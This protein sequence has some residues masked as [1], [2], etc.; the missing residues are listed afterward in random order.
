M[1][2]VRWLVLLSA[3]A[4][5]VVVPAGRAQSRPYIGY[6]YPAGGK[7]GT[8]FEV[9]L[10]GQNLNDVNGVLVTGNGVSARVVEYCFPLGNRESGW[11]SR[12][13]ADLKKSL[14]KASSKKKKTK[15]ESTSSTPTAV[16]PATTNLIAR[17]E[18]LLRE[19]MR[20]PACAAFRSVVF[21][22]VTI[23]PDA[24]PGERELRLMT[25]RGG[26]SNPMAFHVGL[27]TENSR[28]AMLTAPRQRLGK[29]SQAL[30]N[31][32]S[33]EAEERINIPCTVNGQ[34][35][36]REVNSYRFAARKGQQLVI[37]TLARQLIP[38]I[39]DG[40]PG[41][42]Q[43]VI[44]LYDAN[45]REVAYDDDY[46]FKPDPVILYEVP[47]D[48]E[49]VLA[50]FDAIYR[51][52]NDFIY[53]ITIGELPFISNIYPL[54]GRANDSLTLSIRGFNLNVDKYALNLTGVKPGPYPFTLGSRER[55]TNRVAFMVDTLTETVEKEAN[56]TP[57]QAQF[58][59]LPIIIN[60]RIDKPGDSDVFQFRGRANDT[61]VVEVHARRLDS[62]LDS[63]VRI[64]DM[65]GVLVA[66]NDDCEDL[67]SGLNTHHADSYIMA[68]L[69]SDGIYC[70]H[71][72]DTARHGGDEYGY[73]LRI[74]APRPDF[75]LRVVP[76]SVSLRTKGDASL[77]V[78]AIRKDGFSGD[79]K[80]HLHNPPAGFTSTPV[81]LSRTQAVARLRLRGPSTPTK[82]PVT[83]TVA[84]TTEIGGKGAVHVAVPAE[85]RMQAF[86]WRHLVPAQDL[87]VHVYDP[88]YTPP[89]L[90]VPP[91]L[92]PAQ[93]AK[94]NAVIAEAESKGRKFTKSQVSGLARGIKSLYEKGLLTD[95]FYGD[96]IAELGY[97][98]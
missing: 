92:T 29:E 94:A 45:G 21:I 69:P 13:L 19:D 51:G 15:G 76:S 47:Q 54:G 35:A 67:T 70:V 6:V 65:N 10:G 18:K 33:T 40:V 59:T 61:V 64:T 37:S 44:A 26:A 79:I 5:L 30:R 98:R 62:P 9:K 95:I 87:K 28:K 80:L 27:L 53:R 55:Q 68:R 48:G 88:K 78:Y 58:V 16:D 36:S 81:T 75:E 31:R 49:Y 73:R 56:D 1:C 32:P 93:L 34:I 17:L 8:T 4:L 71:I 24:P 66:F 22:E 72:G 89:P 38:Y 23:A 20:F 7:Q 84:G 3:H 43:P 11:L 2:S 91:E 97:I 60:G 14:P 63:A 12:Q 41:W 86:L 42:F 77:S 96:R 74:S 50:I 85:D 52:R 39:A 25:L 82:A 46:R 57:A 83:L 90:R